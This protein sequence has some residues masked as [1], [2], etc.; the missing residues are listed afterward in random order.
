MSTQVRQSS[1]VDVSFKSSVLQNVR[2]ETPKCTEKK[3]ILPRLLH[4]TNVKTMKVY[5]NSIYDHSNIMQ[6]SILKNLTITCFHW[7][8]PLL[9]WNNCTRSA[10]NRSTKVTMFTQIKAT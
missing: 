5:Y 7:F 1:D 2:E 9:S 3:Q 6:E 10:K 4:S 8:F